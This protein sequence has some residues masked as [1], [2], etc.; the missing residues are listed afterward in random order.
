MRL[1]AISLILLM[2][3]VA[4][5]ACGPA[6]EAD[7][8]K[9]GDPPA[10][11]VPETATPKPTETPKP[12][13]EPTKAPEPTKEPEDPASTPEPAPTAEPSPT[14][15]PTIDPDLID[16]H[17]YSTP[18]PDGI[19]GCRAMNM[20]VIHIKD[21][22]RYSA[23]CEQTLEFDV[24]AHCASSVGTEEQ[25]ACAR[26]RLDAVENLDVRFLYACSAITD[27][28]G[29]TDCLRDALARVDDAWNKTWAAWPGILNTVDSDPDVKAKKIAVADCMAEGG[30]D[31][32][33]PDDPIK[34]QTNNKPDP[35]YKP[36]R[37]PPTQAQ[38]DA[39]KLRDKALDQC[40][41]D[42]GLYE[43]QDS[44][45]NEEVR[46]ILKEDPETAGAL[47]D[48]GLITAMERDGIFPFLMQRRWR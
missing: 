42:R 10:T 46:R 29:A 8:G 32:P 40:A 36:L 30:H 11:E 27:P 34:W 2:A 18:H 9:D 37:E 12:D 39:W 25:L 7:G 44:K 33:D 23:W 17:I 31:R 38:M 48:L 35:D 13:G 43:A 45:W 41:T 21:E 22:L 6:D 1:I 5:M 3:L 20:W 28:D 16:D 26:D 19:E 47:K 15:E 4:L 14:P 24:Q